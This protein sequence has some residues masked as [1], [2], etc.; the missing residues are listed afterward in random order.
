LSNFPKPSFINSQS[1]FSLVWFSE[2]NQFLIVQGALESFFIEAIEKDLNYYDLLKTYLVL[3][4]E[5]SDLLNAISVDNT[6]SFFE[7]CPTEDY[8]S[9]FLHNF[10]VSTLSLGSQIVSTFYS[11]KDLQIIFQAPFAHLQTNNSTSNKELIIS[12]NKNKLNL[13]SEKKPV[14]TTHKDHFFILQAQFAIQLT[15]IYHSIDKPNWLCAFHACALQNKNKTFMLLGNSGVGKSTLSCLLSLSDY[16]FIA[17]DLVLMD[18]DFKIYDNPSAVSVKENAWPVIET[19]Y[20]PFYT[21]KTSEKR[22]GKTKMKFLPLHK[23]QNNTPQSFK[24]DALVW[25]NYSKNQKCRLSPLDKQQA[26][27]RLIPDT[28]INSKKA[29][30]KSFTDWAINIKTYRLDYSDFKNAKKLLDVQ[31]Q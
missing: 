14:C 2:T 13:F 19:F 18:H 15:C 6:N 30:A 12:E 8:C 31:L 25:I 24:V 27:S 11:S 7:D 20:K 16:R 26:L 29:S 22:K 1:D 21:L 4:P 9:L 28:W 10:M 3:Y 17:D 23:I 5:I